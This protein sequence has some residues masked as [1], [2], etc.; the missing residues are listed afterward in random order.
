M[1]TSDIERAGFRPASAAVVRAEIREGRG[2]ADGGADTFRYGNAE[3]LHQPPH[4]AENVG[5]TIPRR[6][7]RPVALHVSSGQSRAYTRR[8]PVTQEACRRNT[9]VGAGF[10][11]ARV[12]IASR[13]PI[14]APAGVT[15]HPAVGGTVAPTCLIRAIQGLH[16]P[17]SSR[18]GGVPQEHRCRGGFQT[19]PRPHRVAGR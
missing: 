14:K 4:A 3:F 2:E 19:R 5:G 15:T 12:R 9:G 10:K 11:P 7:D 17:R 18:P 13:R 6:G 1:F 8:V 16:P